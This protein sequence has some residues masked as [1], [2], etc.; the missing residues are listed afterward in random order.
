MRAI[1]WVVLDHAKAYNPA[2]GDMRPLN[3]VVTEFATINL[4]FESSPAKLILLIQK[5]LTTREGK[6]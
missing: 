4:L 1:E 2:F 5:N 6:L 3:G